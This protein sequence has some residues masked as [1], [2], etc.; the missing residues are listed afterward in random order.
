M[1]VFVVK[2]L[3]NGKLKAHWRLL[4][5]TPGAWFELETFLFYVDSKQLIW[6]IIH[7]INFDNQH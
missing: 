5:E 4:I 7:Q 3:R 1:N 2:R 6:E